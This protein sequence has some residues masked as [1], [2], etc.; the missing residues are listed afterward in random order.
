MG[1]PG[2]ITSVPCMIDK[3]KLKTTK[4]IIKIMRDKRVCRL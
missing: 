3:V 1:F 4:E 2:I